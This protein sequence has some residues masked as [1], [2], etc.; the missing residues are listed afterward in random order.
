VE[1][2]A[3]AIIGFRNLSMRPASIGPVK[4]LLRQVDVAELR[5]LYETTRAAGHR[6][7]RRALEGWLE[8]RG[9]QI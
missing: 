3:F 4:A 5:S 7:F 8:E 1:A 9:F 2:L 6:S